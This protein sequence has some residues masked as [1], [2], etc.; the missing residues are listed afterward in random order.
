MGLSLAHLGWRIYSY[1]V[2]NEIFLIFKNY[3]GGDFSP[4][5][6]KQFFFIS[7]NLS[8]GHALNGQ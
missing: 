7:I 8:L 2:R 5:A 4:A 6:L 3:H 1:S